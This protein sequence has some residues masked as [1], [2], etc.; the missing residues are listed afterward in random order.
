MRRMAFEKV[1]TV[2][3]EVRIVKE[4]KKSKMQE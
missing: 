3:E 1:V 2:E 4:V